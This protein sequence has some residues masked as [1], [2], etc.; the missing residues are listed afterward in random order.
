[1]PLSL[2]LNVES[3]LDSIDPHYRALPISRDISDRGREKRKKKKKKEKKEKEK[4]RDG[5]FTL[6]FD[7]PSRNKAIQVL[8]E[9]GV[10]SGGGSLKV[11]RD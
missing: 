11:K 8:R 6:Y 9:N 2:L 7:W 1:M 3:K 10:V 5:D 4:T